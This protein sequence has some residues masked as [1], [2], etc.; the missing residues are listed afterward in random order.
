MEGDD[1]GRGASPL[2]AIWIGGAPV[3]DNRDDASKGRAEA[4]F[5]WLWPVTGLGP[6]GESPAPADQLDMS[7]ED[8]ERARAAGYSVAVVMH[9][10][11]SDWAKQ[12][13]AGLRDTLIRYGATLVDVVDCEFHVERQVAALEGLLVTRPNAVISIPVDN[14][15]TAEAHRA[16]AGVGIK[17]VLM[18]N[19]PVGLLPGAHYVS[20]VSADN[21]GN[22]Q[23]AASILSEYVPERGMAGI[24]GF[25][26]DFYVTN[27]R[28][29]GFRKWMKERRPDVTLHCV[30]FVD[31]ASAGQVA[32]DLLSTVPLDGLFVV[33]DDPA[34]AVVRALREAGQDVPLTTIDLGAEVAV[35]MARGGMVKGL[36]A[37]LPYD[38]GV[39]EATAAIMALA[40]GEPPPWIAMPALPVTRDSVLDA[41]AAVWRVPPPTILREAYETGA[42][43]PAGDPWTE[44]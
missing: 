2:R 19:A 3:T 44:R 41:Y 16:L 32:R 35:E 42:R 24:V 1:V 12:Q 14:A 27:E 38:L 30:E 10:T 43:G 8:A 26:V 11:H 28:E 29:L 40:G 39:A 7:N 21:F 6:H 36:G 15:R 20:V 9:T 34:M 18:D 17:L 25:S 5:D 22:G 13:L 23:V 31:I 37:Q 33:W 4:A